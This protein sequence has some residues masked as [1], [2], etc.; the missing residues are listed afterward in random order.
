MRQAVVQQHAVGQVGQ[1]IVLGQVRHLHRHGTQFADVAE[2]HD[3][4]DDVP[5]LSRIG[6]AESSIGV[7]PPSRR[8]NAVSVCKATTAVVADR[9]PQR[10]QRRFAVRQVDQLDHGVDRLAD[11]LALG[12]SGHHLGDGIEQGDAQVVIADDH[13]VADRVQRHLD[14]LLFLNS[15]RSAGL[16]LADVVGEH[17]NTL[18]RRRPAISRDIHDRCVATGDRHVETHDLARQRAADVIRK[19]RSACPS[20]SISADVRP[21]NSS[22]G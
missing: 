2:H 10:R 16:A 17:E 1:V 12:P 19:H 5:A 9:D 18:H 4:A 21:M 3:A 11:G 15:A 7:S 13:G 22:A 6:A 14:A 20:P 8:R